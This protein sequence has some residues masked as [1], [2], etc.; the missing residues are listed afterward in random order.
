MR[1][2]WPRHVVYIVGTQGHVRVIE[3]DDEAMIQITPTALLASAVSPRSAALSVRLILRH[4]T[5]AGEAWFENLGQAEEGR[6]G[7][8]DGSQKRTSP[9]PRQHLRSASIEPL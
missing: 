2:R 9:A 1:G 5:F 4:Y 6:M 3:G 8:A 7:G